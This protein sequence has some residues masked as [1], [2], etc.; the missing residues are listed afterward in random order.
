MVAQKIVA[1]TIAR[2][3]DLD[4]SHKFMG[5]IGYNYLK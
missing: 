1:S 4:I 2:M 5:W 3:V